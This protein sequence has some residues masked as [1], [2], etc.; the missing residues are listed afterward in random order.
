MRYRERTSA[1]RSFARNLGKTAVQIVCFWSLFLFVLPELVERAGS[2]LGVDVDVAFKWRHAIAVSLFCLASALGLASAWTM[3][4]HGDGTP[5][6]IDTTN[7]LV[8]SGP[9]AY[10]RNPMAVAGL[11][12]GVAVA[13]HRGSP[14]VLLYVAVGALLWQFG[15]RPHEERELERRFGDEFRVYSARVRCWLP[16]CSW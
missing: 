16:R 13:I 10:V 15:A 3:V 11:L 8:T 4:R 14:L 5:L 2:A 6:P 7:R 9:Y 1:T 12:Q